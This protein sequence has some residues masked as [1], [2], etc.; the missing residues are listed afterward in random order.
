MFLGDILIITGEYLMPETFASALAVG[1]V[2]RCSCH[3]W[4][5]RLRRRLSLLSNLKKR[6]K[7]AINMPNIT[8]IYD[9]LRKAD[10]GC[11]PGRRYRH[12]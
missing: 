5:H 3:C 10:R 11:G 12:I 7:S 2:G 1:F 6:L 4:G 8:Y 9:G